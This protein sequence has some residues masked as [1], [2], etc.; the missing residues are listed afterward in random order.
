MLGVKGLG[1][2]PPNSKVFALFFII[3]EKK[4]LARVVEI[5]CIFQR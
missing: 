2:V 4:I 1:K 3:Q 5:Q